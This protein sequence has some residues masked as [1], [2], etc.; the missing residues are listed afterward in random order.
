MIR[1]YISEI[2]NR[3]EKQKRLQNI[4]KDDSMPSVLEKKNVSMKLTFEVWTRA[5]NSWLQHQK[6]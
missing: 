3:Q 5:P 4:D 2:N 1:P 6:P